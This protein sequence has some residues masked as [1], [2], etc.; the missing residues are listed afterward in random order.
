MSYHIIIPSV[1]LV[2]ILAMAGAI[3][4]F[5][6]LR[7]CYQIIGI[8]PPE[9][10]QK[11]YPFNSKN[12]IFMIFFVQVLFSC[13]AFLLFNATSAYDYGLSFYMAATEL[14]LLVYYPIIIFKMP[15]ILTL[16]GN[17]E[18]FIEKSKWKHFL[19]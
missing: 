14:L 11:N 3:K 17:F 13:S 16:I 8:Y 9:T 15:D 7:K 18:K 2:L 4:L 12:I 10:N 19:S 6:F 5:Q 1:S